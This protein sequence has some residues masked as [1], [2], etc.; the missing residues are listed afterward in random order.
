MTLPTTVTREGMLTVAEGRA[1]AM[2]DALLGTGRADAPR[3]NVAL[4]SVRRE[5]LDVAA[6]R[7]AV[8]VVRWIVEAGG[9]RTR[10]VLREGR[11]VSGRAWD[12]HL[13]AGFRP[14]FTAATSRLWLEAARSLP[15]IAARQPADVQPATDGERRHRRVLRDMVETEGTRSGDWVF[16][17]MVQQSL[18][19][20]RLLPDD[21]RALGMKLRLASP[22]ATL[23]APEPDDLPSLRARLGPLAS[24]SAARIME[25]AED[26]VAAAWTALGRAAWETREP[27]GKVGARW[28][29]LGRVQRAWLDVTDGAR[30]LDLARPVAK[31]ARALVTRTVGGDGESARKRLAGTPGVRNIRDRDELLAA[32]AGALEPG[33]ALLRRRDEMAGERYGD[34]RYDE[35]QVFVRDV[36]EILGPCRRE[37]LGVA[38]ALSGEIS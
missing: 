12:S 27:P 6:Q 19:G 3:E 5:L 15:G 9:Y 24:T 4:K 17:A 21:L 2:L 36:D 34:E 33:V 38:R 14:E 16:F 30:R 31:A 13:G 18:G 22:V 23:M 20:F 10:Q 32:V 25:C 1:L 37:I 8:T 35:A 7:I 11:R 26:R 29:A 28:T